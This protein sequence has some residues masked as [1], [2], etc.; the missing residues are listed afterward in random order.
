MD[1]YHISWYLD[2]FVIISDKFC[3]L[4]DYTELYFQMIEIY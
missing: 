2:I 3:Y 1:I 4:K